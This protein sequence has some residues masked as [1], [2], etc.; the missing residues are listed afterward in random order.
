MCDAYKSYL[1]NIYPHQNQYTPNEQRRPGY[2]NTR[3]TTSQ[4][5]GT[6]LNLSN[7]TVS[8]YVNNVQS[9]NQK[10]NVTKSL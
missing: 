3:Q 9:K 4:I 7:G 8:K 10:R 5:L 2:G 6:K 1:E